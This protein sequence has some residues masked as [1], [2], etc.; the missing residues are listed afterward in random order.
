MLDE[1]RAVSLSLVQLS[2]ADARPGFLVLEAN[3]SLAQPARE[4]VAAGVIVQQA[5]RVRV[6]RKQIK[7]L[8]RN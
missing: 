5:A 1:I 8:R 3:R 2:L 7:Q 4:K 6:N